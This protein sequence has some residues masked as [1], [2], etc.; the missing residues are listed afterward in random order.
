MRTTFW[1]IVVSVMLPVSLY[2]QSGNINNTLGT[3]GS[4]KVKSAASDSLFV[5]KENGSVG[6]GTDS[7]GEKLDLNGNLNVRGTITINSATRYYS[8]AGAEL[9]PW[10]NTSFSYQKGA[11][12]VNGLISAETIV[13]Y[14]PVHLPHGVTITIINVFVLDSDA[15]QEMTVELRRSNLVIATGSSSGSPGSTT[16]TM[17][18][19]SETVNNYNYSYVLR[20][21]WTTS[22]NPLQLQFQ[23]A[24]ITYSVN[25]PAP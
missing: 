15:I 16:I 4:F 5:V 3:G 17:S 6:I 23:R 2:A 14:V 22:A 12:A 10:N 9:Q 18:D 13:F 7:P 19:L 1:G 24:L 11:E 8:I 25:N 20:V 21:V